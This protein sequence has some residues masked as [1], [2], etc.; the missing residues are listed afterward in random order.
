MVADGQPAGGRSWDSVAAGGKVKGNWKYW[1]CSSG[2]CREW[3]WRTLWK[4]RSCGR[5]APPWVKAA[6]PPAAGA[7]QAPPVADAQGFVVQPRGRKA[8]RQAK[9]AAA[10]AA[11]A[12]AA[13]QA[14]VSGAGSA[15]PSAVER[16]RQEVKRIEDFLA[17]PGGAIDEACQQSLRAALD[18]ERRRPSAA[19]AAQ[20]ERRKADIPLPKALHGAGNALGKLGRQGRAKEQALLK[21]E[22]AHAAAIGE[23]EAAIEREAACAEAV[24]EC[25]AALEAHREEQKAAEARQAQEVGAAFAGTDLLG[26]VFGLIQQ[27]EALPQGFAAGNGEAAFAEVAKQI[28]AVRRHAPPEARG[29]SSWADTP[30]D[31][32]DEDLDGDEAAGERA[33]ETL[34]GRS[35]AAVPSDQRMS[36]ALEGLAPLRAG[37]EVLGCNGNVWNRSVEVLEAFFH[38]HQYW[39]QL[40]ILQETSSLRPFATASSAYEV[41]APSGLHLL[42]LAGYFQHSLGPRGINLDLFSSVADLVA[43]SLD[44]PWVLQ[45]GFNMEPEPL[46]ELGWPA[47]VRGQ[48]LGPSEATCCAQ[49]LEHVYDWFVASSDLA[50]CTASCT[51]TLSDV[52]L[53]PHSPVLLRLQDVRCDALVEVPSRPARFTDVEVK[54]LRSREDAMVQ[55]FAVGKRG[56]VSQKAVS[57]SWA[58]GSRPTCLSEALSEWTEAAEGTL[59]G[60]HGIAPGDLPR[61]L[62]RAAGPRTRRMPF[63]ALVQRE[64]RLK[65]S[66]LTHRLRSCLSVAL[67]RLRAEQASR[68]HPNHTWWYEQEAAARAKLLDEAAQEV[69]GLQGVAL[70]GVSD[71]KWVTSPTT[72]GRDAAEGAAAWRSWAQTAVE[73]GG[74]LAHRFSKATP[75]PV[76]RDADTGRPLVG[77]D[78]V[79]QLTR[80]WQR[81]WLQE[82]F[83]SGVGAHRWDVGSW[84]LPPITL[85]AFQ[86]A[87]KRFGPSMGLGCDNLHPRQLLLLPVALQLRRIDIL[88][89]FEDEPSSIVGQVTL[90]VCI[91]KADGGT[92]PIALLP[93]A[94]RLW[95]RLRQPCCARWESDHNFPFV[96]G[97]DGRDCERAGWIHNC[98]AGFAMASPQ[99]EVASLFLDIR[100]FYEHVRHDVPWASAQRFGFNLKL[101]RGLLAIYQAPRI[102]LAGGMASPPFGASGTVLAGCACAT[103]AAKLPLLGGLL[104]A[105]AQ[106]PLTT[107]RN[108]VGDVSFQVVGSARLVVDQLAGASGEVLRHLRA[109]HLPLNEGKS[110]FL[111]SSAQVADGLAASWAALGFEVKRGL[112]A[113]SLGTDANVT[114][115]GVHEGAARAVGGLSRARR[116]RTLR[117]AGAAVVHMHSAGPS[118]AMLRGRTVAGVPD[119][120]LHSRRLASARSAGKLPKGASLGLRLRAIEVQRSA[121]LDPSPALVR[122]A[123]QMAASLL[124]TGEVPLRMFATCLVE[125]ERR[126]GSARAPWVH[127]RNPVDPLALSLTRVGWR[128]SAGHIL[129][130]DDGHTLDML[131]M[132]PRE[133][134][135]LAA[136][137]ARRASDRAEMTRLGHGAAPSMPLFWDALGQVIGPRGRFSCREKAAVVSYLSNAHWP[138]TRLFAS[139]ERGHSRCCAC[140]EARGSLWHRLFE[141]Q[142]LAAEK[143][144]S[145]SA[146][147]LRRATRVRQRGEETGGCFSRCWLPQP[148]QTAWRSDA[149]AVMW[150]NKPADGLLGGRLHLDG[151]AL[152]PEFERIRRAGWSIVQCDEHGNM[153]AAVCGTVRLDL[154][155]FQTA[156][157]GEDFAVWM[158]SRYLGP[159]IIELNI[160]CA[161][162]VSCLKLGRKYA[163]AANK[164]NAHLWSA[165][166][167]SLDVD[168]LKVNK[169]AAHCTEIDVR[170]G[171]ISE[172]HWRG[173]SHADR[174]AKAGAALHR[175]S[176]AARREFFGAMEVVREL[177][178]WVAQ[179]SIVWQGRAPK[180][181]EGLPEGGERRT[182]V[183]FAVPLEERADGLLAVP[184]SGSRAAPAAVEPR[185]EQ[186]GSRPA[187]DGARASAARDGGVGALVFAF[188][189]HALAHA[190]LGGRSGTQPKL[191]ERRPGAT[192]LPK[193]LRDQ[194][195]RWE[196]GLHP[197]GTPRVRNTR[198]KGAEAARLRKE[199]EVPQDARV[200]FLKWL[201]VQPDAPAGEER[202]ASVAG[203]VGG[204][205]GGAA[206]SSTE[207]PAAAG[208]AAAGAGSRQAWLGAHG[209]DE[210]S[211]QSWAAAAEEA[212]AERQ[213]RKRRRDDGDGGP[214]ADGDGFVQQ[215]RGRSAQRAARRAAA[216]SQRA[217]SGASAAPGSAPS[218]RA[219][220]KGCG[221]GGGKAGSEGQSQLE[222]L[223]RQ[224]AEAK[225]H[226]GFLLQAA[227]LA[228]RSDVFRREAEEAL[229]AERDRVL[230]LES[231]LQKAQLVERPPH[232]VL[233]G[234]AN[235]IQKAERQLVKA[236]ATRER[237][238]QEADTLKDSIADTQEKL[239]CLEVEIEEAVDEIAKLEETAAQATQQALLRANEVFG[240]S[241]GELSAAVRGLLMQAHGLADILKQCSEGVPPRLVEIV[242]YLRTQGE[243]VSG[244]LESRASRAG[245]SGAALGAWPQPDSGLRKSLA[246][247]RAAMVD[248]DALAAVGGTA[249]GALGGAGAL[250]CDSGACG[251]G[252]GATVQAVLGS[253]VLD[254]VQVWKPRHAQEAAI[255]YQPA[256]SGGG[257]PARPRAGLE[258]LGCNGNAW[259]RSVEVLE[260]FFQA[261]GYW[262]QLVMPQETRLTAERISGARSMARGLGY[263]AFFHEAAP[264]AQQGPL[265]H[266][267]AV[268]TLVHSSLQAEESLFQVPAALRHRP[269]G[270]E[271]VPASRLRL[272]AAT[273]YFH[274]SLG[275]GGINL[276][277]FT[278][279]ADLVASSS[280]MPRVFQ[281]D[282]NME[283]D[284][285]QELGWPAA[286]RGQVLGPSGPTCCSE[287][288][289]HIYGVRGDALV[290]APSRPARFPD[291]AV[292]DLRARGGAPLQA[293][294][295]GKKGAVTQLGISRPWAAGELPS[296][297]STALREWIGVAEGTLAGIH[298]VSFADLAHFLGRGAGPRTVRKPF[299]ALVK[300]EAR[301]KYSLLTHH[302]R[303]CLDGAPQRLRAVKTDRWHPRHP[304]WHEREAAARARLLAKAAQEAAAAGSEALLGVSAAQ[305]GDLV[306]HAGAS[307]CPTALAKLQSWLAASQRRDAAAG[308]AAWRKW[309]QTAV[310]KGGRLAHRFSKPLVGMAAIGQLTETRQRLWLQEGFARGEGASRWGVGRWTLPP[311]TLEEEMPASISGQVVLAVFIPKAEHN[312]PFFRWREGRDCERAGWIHNYFA[313]FAMATPQFEA[314]S[315]F[316]DIS[317]FYEHVRRDVLWETAQRFSFNLKL[318]RGLLAIYQAPRLVWA[319]GIASA[320]F[321]ARGTVL[322]GCARATA[323]AKLSVLGA[324]LATGA[325][326][327]LVTPRNVVDEISLQAAG[328]ARLVLDQLVGCSCEVARQLR[329]GHLPLNESKT[330]FLASSPQLARGL[331]AAWE[332]RGLSFK[333]GLQARNL[334][335]DANITR[336]GVR[337]GA[338]RAAGSLSRA[339][340]RRVLQHAGAPVVVVHRAGP[341]AATLR[342]RTVT[343][344]PDGELRSWRLAAARY[345]GKV[346]RGAALG[347]R[348]RAA[349]VLRSSDLD[350]SPALVRHAVQMAASLLQSGEVPLRALAACLAEAD[351]RHASASAPWAHCRTTAG[352][353]ALSLARIDWRVAG[354][355][356]LVAE[357]GNSMDL[358]LVGPRELRGRSEAAG[359][360]FARGWLPGP[361]RAA[362]RTDAMAATWA[363][364]PEGG[365]LRGRLFLD[366]SAMD[367]EHES[368]RR[369]GWSIV[370]CDA[371]GDLESEVYGTVCLDLC[372][373]QTAKDGEDFAVWMLSRFAGLNVE[374]LCIDCASTVS[375]L[376]LGRKYAT[377]MGKPNAH[378]WSA[379]HASLDVDTLKVAKVAAH[380][381]AEDVREGRI[382]E[383]VRRGNSH[384]DH[385][386]KGLFGAM[387]VVLELT[388]WIAQASLIWQGIEAKDCQ[389]PP[390]ASERRS[391]SFAEPAVE[392]QGCGADD[393]EQELVACANCS[394]YARLGDRAGARPKLKDRCPGSAGLP[395]AL[396]NQRSLRER[397]PHPA[398]KA[399]SG[400]KR[401]KD[402]EAPRL[403]KEA[404]V[405]TDAKIRFVDWFGVRP[406]DRDG[407]EPVVPGGTAGSPGAA[408]AAPA[409]SVAPAAGA[410]GHAASSRQAWLDAHGLDEAAL[411][412]W[413]DVAEA[414][415]DAHGQHEAALRSSADRAH[416][417]HGW[418]DGACPVRPADH[419][420][421]FGHE[422]AM[423]PRGEDFQECD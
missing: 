182:A 133:L 130:T 280:D 422:R 341:T 12:G 257:P 168:S 310:E 381:R 266:S 386:A 65:Y 83:S 235:A 13:S 154:C 137:G 293:F 192:G 149:M 279:F 396:R 337:E 414:W 81:L 67:Q 330:V 197:G 142:A 278:A 7:G 195:S 237:K 212:R 70:P 20:A 311:I 372:P 239:S 18:R 164:P 162:T 99:F 287:G 402:A 186:A 336:R 251:L 401:D 206:S 233:R 325:Q 243:A 352:A 28:A 245:Q 60:I 244:L 163:T 282:F 183:T 394:A 34:D 29:R 283:P 320:A 213:S 45:I 220:G 79:D 155:P 350:P 326:R 23:R 228:G 371:D 111:A 50:T 107:L 348:L 256:L 86:Q 201:G 15:Q 132:G 388:R 89:A 167:A 339:R 27:V 98:F 300:R 37:L 53:H 120:E 395:K 3:N 342:G 151:S 390:E 189:G 150:V 363:N 236:R 43:F 122:A 202:S 324:L 276:D 408:A 332:A 313:G 82:G 321:S 156:K 322:A 49:G 277:I 291:A 207:A 306:H 292:G 69:A 25:R 148:P 19:E 113:R 343:R 375:C 404:T 369:A 124:Q 331:A 31:V 299:S 145:L 39:P 275:P 166:Y 349:E 136:A 231:A 32:S 420:V 143:R 61:Y 115:R 38:P 175:V 102:V 159:S 211:L 346:P 57:W 5:V 384:A 286:L 347:L 66:M 187:D 382:S 415:L 255:G 249:S 289:E 176:A 373:L 171:R 217:A 123:V 367:P 158:L 247:A 138:Q 125:A 360:N 160:D 419:R 190:R 185:G 44:L 205:A 358:L 421:N 93:L 144:D 290:D 75:T 112:Q 214:L 114:R 96:W 353:L 405:P 379:I 17:A 356:Y 385:W 78:A 52:G 47:A 265:A 355:N 240:C 104:A 54:G 147:L 242:G 129:R 10:R 40:V 219:R 351:R 173:N 270:V 33:A 263:S 411:R 204:G 271:V 370:Q 410:S 97:R 30:F 302:I 304:G 194:K 316:L 397:G 68:W 48:V 377:A 198:T 328:S 16:H 193:S 423:R 64:A 131:L 84:T 73:K 252:I 101:L 94:L 181:C 172:V 403:R 309:A 298:E 267:G 184:A 314:A 272:L 338:A 196:R 46:Q 222:G 126:H 210:E 36:R 26:M 368:L 118:A 110:V 77:M 303:S 87:C 383:A 109:H 170:E 344:V 121:D 305:W 340:R 361:P 139:G 135:L 117:S 259:G 92:R 333:R 140:G 227:A 261:H 9:R 399:H 59:T 253:E 416:L 90:M 106:R 6:Q 327:P 8:R 200:R 165:V 297:L 378:L 62:G 374:E 241:Q 273:G 157:D 407:G 41:T 323:V 393:D 85:D 152:D 2:Q 221:K 4:C 400:N 1:V 56:K 260:A 116:L 308:A 269:I 317:K 345:A 398:G 51:T 91:P 218:S 417:F 281:A 288:A 216:A 146:R 234:E 223:R 128:L 354:G 191:K 22:E 55:A 418:S 406:P 134:G 14:G 318:P 153:Q 105:G 141:C 178:R 230:A 246:E 274:H 108:L 232:A 262:P 161:S 72:R 169:V 389:G 366:G 334:G 409:A 312:S 209:L 199:A 177:S 11:S 364:R 238:V 294:Q 413:A 226:V 100:K 362:P 301:L 254:A 119:G 229:Q 95:S 359:E 203:A 391:V 264:T 285:L 376:K 42:A 35:E 258:V 295:V 188:A 74:R 179:A 319:G 58:Q 224:L 71:V 21:A 250:L 225:D 392:Q 248:D 365:L 357:D 24:E 284:G 215:P 268:A 63:S 307:G 80:S 296:N 174:L 76:V 329:A 315:V 103:A 127:C 88:T 412:S 387:L 380:C 208:D 335:A 180:D